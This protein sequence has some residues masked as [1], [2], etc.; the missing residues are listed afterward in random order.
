MRLCLLLGLDVRVRNYSGYLGTLR[1][2][3]RFPKVDS[4][5]DWRLV[6]GSLCTLG[7]GNVAGID[8][9]HVSNQPRVT[10]AEFAPPSST[11]CVAILAQESACKKTP[12]CVGGLRNTLYPR[13]FVLRSTLDLQ[14]IRQ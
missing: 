2:T 9:S 7:E 14:P 5:P 13:L 11:S 1:G 12:L 10:F 6:L 3:L 4:Y 8:M